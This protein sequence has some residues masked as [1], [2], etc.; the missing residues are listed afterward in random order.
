MSLTRLTSGSWVSRERER[1][2]PVEAGSRGHYVRRNH[3]LW[4][5]LCT[6]LPEEGG[7]RNHILLV[8]LLPYNCLWLIG[9]CRV[10][11]NRTHTALLLGCIWLG[12]CARVDSVAA[13]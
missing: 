5:C 11:C 10:Q 9:D 4:V 6:V 7:S 3:T 2:E 13:R 1:G 12:G 8:A